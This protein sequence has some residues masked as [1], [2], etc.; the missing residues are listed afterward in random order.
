MTDD[1][2][3][4]V[5]ALLDTRGEL[6]YGALAVRRTHHVLERAAR[7]PRPNPHALYRQRLRCWAIGWD[8]A[9]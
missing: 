6:L 1:L 5:P 3:Y 7:P 9:T 4:L 8:Q 2:W